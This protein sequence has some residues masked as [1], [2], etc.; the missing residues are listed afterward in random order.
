MADQRQAHH[1]EQ[2]RE[3][4]FELVEYRVHASDDGHRV[5]HLADVADGATYAGHG[6]RPAIEGRSAQIEVVVQ[7]RIVE[8][9]SARAAVEIPADAVAGGPTVGERIVSAAADDAPDIARAQ[10]VGSVAGAD[11]ACTSHGESHAYRGSREVECYRT[12]GIADGIRTP[13]IGELERIVA[14]PAL[15]D[16]VVQVAGYRVVAGTPRH[17]LEIADP[18]S[19]GCGACR[20]IDRNAGRIRGE[21]DRVDAADAAIDGAAS[22]APSAKLNVL[23]PLP[24]TRLS[25]ALTETGAAE[26]VTA[27]VPPV[28]V[29]LNVRSEESPV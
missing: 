22:V 7:R 19:A 21:A 3:G 5:L 14:A 20:Q 4:R 1:A 18:G 9:I 6:E 13:A 17:I 26:P 8:R 28:P 12:T 2:A 15:Q 25:K 29:M 16:V 11:R 24:P 10:R 23:S 27:T